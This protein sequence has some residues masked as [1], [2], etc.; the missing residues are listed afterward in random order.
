[1]GYPTCL[2]C[3]YRYYGSMRE[4]AF[5]SLDNGRYVVLHVSQ[6]VVGL[7][8]AMLY[9]LSAVCMYVHT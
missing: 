4:C 9:N 7:L 6:G 1:M 2:I 5:V 3:L 8:V